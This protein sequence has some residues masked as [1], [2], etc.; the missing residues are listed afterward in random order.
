MINKSLKSMKLKSFASRYSFFNANMNILKHYNGA[1]TYTN[2]FSYSAFYKYPNFY[3][4]SK[5]K[6]LNYYSIE[7]V[8]KVP[9]LGDSISEGIISEYHKRK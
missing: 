1:L 4:A 7:S 6:S 8:M 2:K 9:S 3:F 5:L